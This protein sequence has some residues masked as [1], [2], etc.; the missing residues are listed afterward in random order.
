MESGLVS[1]ELQ[2]VGHEGLVVLEDAAVPGVGVDL[3]LGVGESTCHVGGVAAV[4]HEVVVAVGD[5]DGLG[6]DGEVVGCALAGVSD[7]LDLGDA[8]LNRDLLVAVVGAF[9]EAV[10]VVRSRPVCLRG[11]GG[12]RGSFWGRCA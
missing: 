1:E 8:G 10:Q 7:G 3:Q 5:Q 4:D 11:C 9:L 12:R 6:D 2:G